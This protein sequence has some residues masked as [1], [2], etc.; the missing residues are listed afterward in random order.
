M[1]EALN[2]RASDP[3]PPLMAVILG[4]LF[5]LG[6]KT[7]AI[8]VVQELLF[9]MG[10]GHFMNCLLISSLLEGHPPEC[11][12]TLLAL[13]MLILS[14]PLTSYNFTAAAFGK[15]TWTVIALLFALQSMLRLACKEEKE[16]SWK[17]AI[18]AA[19]AFALSACLLPSQRCG[20]AASCL[21]INLVGRKDGK[22][23]VRNAG[24]DHV[25]SHC[26]LLHRAGSWSVCEN[27]QST[28]Y[29]S[30]LCR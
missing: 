29:P 26:L 7:P 11:R 30:Y 14:L 15:D 17:A 19:I 25:P 5:N 28:H 1:P 10:L 23:V 13:L 20:P 16:I 2:W 22:A 8:F 6:F 24:D 9:W 3:H 4:S 27:S 18:S 21:C 12:A